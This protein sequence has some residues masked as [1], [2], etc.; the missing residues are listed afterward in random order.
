[1]TRPPL[2]YTT[3]IKAGLTVAECTGL[4][5][6]AGA[7]RV[8]VDYGAAREP[9]GLA[10]RLLMPSGWQDFVLPVNIDAVHALLKNADYPASVKTR[11]LSRYVTREHAERVAWRVVKDWLEAQLAIIEAE[12]VTLDQVMLPYL[13]LRQGSLYEMVRDQHLTLPAGQPL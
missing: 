13:Q 1:M 9:T 12:M 7:A 3:T 4:L 6:R 10:F 8:A 5:A 11:D 2:N